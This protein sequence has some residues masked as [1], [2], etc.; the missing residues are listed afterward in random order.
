MLNAKSIVVGLASYVAAA[1][2]AEAANTW[3]DYPTRSPFAEVRWPDDT[4]EIMVDSKWYVLLSIDDVATARI[5]SFCHDEW[6]GKWQKRFE[7]DL[8]EVLSRLGSKPG[9]TVKLRLRRLDTGETVELASVKMTSEN[10]KMLWSARRKRS[11]SQR[12]RDSDPQYWSQH[13]SAGQ[14]GADVDELTRVLETQY[15]YLTL[16]GFDYRR[17][18]AELRQRFAAGATRRQF[19]I[20]LVKIIARFGD[21]HTRVRK[22]RQF[23][24]EGF[25]PFVIAD[26]NGRL[27]ALRS[28]RSGLLDAAYPYLGRID[29][30]DA[31]HWIAT[32]ARFAADGSPQF[33]RSRAIEFA[34]WTQLIRKELGRDTTTSIAIGL[35]DEVGDQERTLQLPIEER[36]PEF[37]V[38][39]AQRSTTRY[40]GDIG[41]LPLQQ[42]RSDDQFLATLSRSMNAMRD[43]RSLIID[44]RGNGGGSRAALRML[45]PYFMRPHDPTRIVNAAQYRLR[46]GDKPDA[47]E[48]HLENRWLYPLAASRWTPAQRTAITRFAAGF[49]PQ[50]HTPPGDFSAWHY[51]AISADTNRPGFHYDKA[52]VILL[53]ERCFSATDIFLGAF[54]G[55]RNVTLLGRASAGGSGRSELITL[56]HS[57]LQVR[58]SS[59]ASFRPDGQLYDGHGI[60][61]DVLIQP[62]LDDLLGKTDTT[63]DAA[64]QYLKKPGSGSE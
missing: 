8:V 33:R 63:L 52:V 55:L 42:M 38:R 32:A 61:P 57:G 62:T 28:D 35:E 45:L 60:A 50:W 37:I 43:T 51:M 17:A 2:V 30:V 9:D 53:D 48:G 27:V 46:P 49:S 16:T 22:R 36:P 12:S 11:Q 44:V 19:A 47:P 5:L 26:L 3:R 21:G 20:D 14:I 40:S 41:Y 54:K 56:R 24:P 31:E 6:P 64:L 13:L 15:S 18:L 10:R 58:I 39:R 7:E 1:H 29:G 34:H 59:M 25:A 23:F 4:P